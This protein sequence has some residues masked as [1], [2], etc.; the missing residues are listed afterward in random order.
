MSIDLV[1]QL[2]AMDAVDSARSME[3]QI[4]DAVNLDAKKAALKAKLKATYA[5][6]GLPVTDEALDR[7]VDEFFKRR[8]EFKPMD[9]GLNKVLAGLYIKRVRIAKQMTFWGLAF[10]CATCLFFAARSAKRSY[11]EHAVVAH[12]AQIKDATYKAEL[13]HIAALKAE[14]SRVL[15]EAADAKARIAKLAA[16]PDEIRT[17]AAAIMA[18]SKETEV[19]AHAKDTA[20]SG[21]GAAEAGD[22]R[23]ATAS[24]NDL[25]TLYAD[26]SSEYELRINMSGRK[27]GADWV[28]GGW[29]DTNGN[30]RY[31][32]VVNALH[33]GAPVGVAVRSEETGDT[34]RVSSWA[35]QV[36][37]A[38]FE[39]I[40]AEKVRT[41]SLRDTLFARKERG[42]LNPSYLQG[43][44]AGQGPANSDTYRLTRW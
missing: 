13:D 2:A 37:Q 12:A 10:L 40:K 30:R 35:E 29:R 14:E 32:V 7:G 22:L 43:F 34:T 28:T 1:S 6:Q 38:A 26:L 3:E 8:Y 9:S 4:N 25:Q 19:Q 5:E 17:V 41:N 39:A 33:S 36:S 15:R 16:L 42:Y 44:K 24:L 18:L 20:L 27:G 11:D 31:Y 21:I 23:G